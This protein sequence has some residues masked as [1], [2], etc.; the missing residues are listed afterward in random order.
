V[1]LRLLGGPYA[2]PPV[3]Y[4]GSKRGYATAILAAMGLRPGQGADAVLLCD[5]GPWSRVW[6]VLSRPEGCRE[7]AAI[8]RGWIGEEPRAL[9]ERLRA[10]GPLSG[11]AGVAQYVMLTASNRLINADWRSGGWSN[12]GKGGTTHGGEEFAT[13]PGDVAEAVGGLEGVKWPRE[14]A[15]FLTAAHLSWKSQ[16]EAGFKRT[17][18][19]GW[20]DDAP[21][22]RNLDVGATS[23]PSTA[24]L[25]ASAATIDPRDVAAWLFLQGGSFQYRG[26]QAGIGRPEGN[27]GSDGFGE[28]RPMLDIVGDGAIALGALPWPPSSIATD[29]RLPIPADLPPGSVAYIDPPYQNTTGYANDLPRHEVEEIARRWKDAGALVVISEAEPIALP[30]WHHVEI[31]AERVGQKR[32]FSKQQAEWLTMSAP[33]ACRFGGQVGLFGSAA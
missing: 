29:A 5:P 6:A 10:E 30:G 31:T 1:T 14:V 27:P 8:I 7:V 13:A 26:P 33:P 25:S 28:V 18:G 32:T 4:M 24:I 17:A 21:D 23:W 19:G 16:P 15:G 11:D 22:V 3:S 12:T 9:W 2:K 20:P